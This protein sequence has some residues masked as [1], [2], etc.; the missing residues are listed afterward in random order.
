MTTK[1]VEPKPK[2]KPEKPR[3]EAQVEMSLRAKNRSPQYEELSAADQW[4][5]DKE[6]GILD[7]DGR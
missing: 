2:P 7:W 1:K 6:N 5:E 4:A 3:S